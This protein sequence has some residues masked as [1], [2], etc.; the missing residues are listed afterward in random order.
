MRSHALK[1]AAAQIEEMYT[2]MNQTQ[3]TNSTSWYA[4]R[5]REPLRA[6]KELA[7]MC[8]E[9]FYPTT[10]VKTV[11]GKNRPRPIIPHVLF[12]RTVGRRLLALEHQGRVHPDGNLPFW[13][14]RNPGT[15]EIQPISPRSITLLR[16][17]VSD[18][19][20]P[21]RVYNPTTFTPGQPVRIVGGIYKDYEG[22]VKRI[23]RKR[24]V[25]VEIEGLC[26]VALPH[27]H[28]DLLQPLP[29]A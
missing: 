22:F 23:G 14:Y 20:E 27:I 24:H 29:N 17:I 2:Y 4:I 8:D 9:V 5:T 15:S 16:L 7:P 26:M 1:A 12:V 13:I 21:A 18:T 19:S 25:V 11:Y 3:L 28:P 6:E 10:V